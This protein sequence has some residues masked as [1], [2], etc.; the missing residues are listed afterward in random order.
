MRCLAVIETVNPQ[1][2]AKTKFRNAAN[3][4]HLAQNGSLVGG[5]KY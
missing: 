1:G 4:L 2:G 3:H 5:R